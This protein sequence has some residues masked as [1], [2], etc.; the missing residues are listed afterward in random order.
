MEPRIQYTKTSD[1]VNIAYW[2]LGK[3]E[4]ALVSTSLL[5]Y[6]NI[7]L[8]LARHHLREWYERLVSNRMVVRF[9]ARICGLS[10]RGVSD[11]SIDAFVLDLE[12]VIDRLG[13]ERFDLLACGVTGTTALAYAAKHGDRVSRLAVWNVA[14]HFRDAFGGSQ[15]RDALMSL[16]ERD[17]ET[18][19]QTLIYAALGWPRAGEA[20]DPEHPKWVEFIRASVDQADFLRLWSVLSAVDLSASLSTISSPTLILYSP[21]WP[22]VWEH[23]QILASTIPRAELVRL[24]TGPRNP[25]YRNEEAMRLVEEFFEIRAQAPE[26]GLE[27]RGEQPPNGV[28]EDLRLWAGKPIDAFAVS[29]T[30][31]GLKRP[32]PDH[33]TAREVEVLRLIADGRTRREI[34]EELVLSLRTVARHITNVYGKIGARSKADATAYAIRHNL[35]QD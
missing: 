9:D 15:R 34:S 30:H 25:L 29:E 22:E 24:Q 4:P 26:P 1:G 31:P 28:G 27:D 8:E 35:T 5:G 2:T 23:A 12:A 20:L 13:L 16:A 7:S 18:A 21:A 19:V 17:W 10:E 6:S 33:L 11:L 3:G 32:Y 14:S